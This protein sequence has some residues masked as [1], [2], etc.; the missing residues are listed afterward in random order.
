MVPKVVFRP[1]TL[2]ENIK[3]IEWA[4]FENNGSLDVHQYLLEYYPELSEVEGYDRGVILEKI[5][6]VVSRDYF[7][8]EKKI[9]DEVRRYQSSWDK[10]N[11]KY[12]M[13]ISKYLNCSWDDIREIS[14]SVGLIPVFPRYLDTY[15][16]SI[17]TNVKED[18]LNEKV[19]HE[20]LHFLWFLKWKSLFP[21][22]SRREFDSPFMPWVYSEMVVD[23][24]LNSPAVSKLFDN[25]ARAYDSFYDY[26]YD[27]KSVMSVLKD[28]YLEDNSIE[29]KIVYGYQYV[30][31]AIHSIK[32][33]ETVST[34]SN[35]T[36]KSASS[37]NV[38]ALDTPLVSYTTDEQEFINLINN[39][40]EKNNL[41]PLEIDEDLQN[42]ARLKAE[43]LVKNNYFSHTS[44]TFG[45]LYEMLDDNAI[46]YKIASENIAGNSSISGAVNALMNSEA[47]K[48]NILSNEFNYT[49]VGVVTSP[50]Y[51]KILVQLF[52]G[53]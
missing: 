27:G 9:Y 18:M 12:M 36:E 16:F 39:E 33:N 23:P 22:T 6:E 37:E 13:E 52:I 43:D 26:Q 5:H 32:I 48:K 11:D 50:T 17:S 14:A 21:N 41:S 38:S 40:R 51:G 49:G 3:V 35:T 28:I 4:Y 10:Y 19:A 53:K 30:S 2:E 44:P 45:T 15:S 34:N 29:E 42:V 24:I 20:T 25:S 7:Q 1:M 8:Y 47:H 46:R 31:E